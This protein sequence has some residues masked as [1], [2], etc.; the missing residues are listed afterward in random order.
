MENSESKDTI[1]DFS[2]RLKTVF[3]STTETNWLKLMHKMIPGLNLQK[4]D[5]QTEHTNPMS[6]SCL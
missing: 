5:K 6:T 1:H 2:M 4:I 3:N